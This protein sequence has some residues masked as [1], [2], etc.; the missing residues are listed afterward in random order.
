MSP[1]FWQRNL[2]LCGSPRSSSESRRPLDVISVWP[3]ACYR[4]HWAVPASGARGGVRVR[5]EMEATCVDLYRGPRTILRQSTGGGFKPRAWWRAR[6]G[7]CCLISQWHTVCRGPDPSHVACPCFR[8]LSARP[9]FRAAVP[10]FRLTLIPKPQPL[11]LLQEG[12]RLP[13]LDNFLSMRFFSSLFL[14]PLA[15]SF[16]L[17][18]RSLFLV[19]SMYIFLL[20]SLSFACSRSR[21]LPLCRSPFCP[22]FHHPLPLSPHPYQ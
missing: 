4:P 1:I 10:P 21:P 19:H 6:G 8:F 11:L 13:I 22:W 20:L 7:S 9:C 16:S 15:L 17:S 12:L 18:S 3:S 5:S 2:N 14:P